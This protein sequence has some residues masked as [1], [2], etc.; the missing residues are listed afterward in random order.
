V[1]EVGFADVIGEGV[2]VDAAEHDTAEVFEVVVAA[3]AEVSI[4][5]VDLEEVRIVTV[6]DAPVVASMNLDRDEEMYSAGHYS[7]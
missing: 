2:L 5:V 4:Q 6:A 3:E 7:Y 1:G